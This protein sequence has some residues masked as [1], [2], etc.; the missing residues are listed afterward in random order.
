MFRE[1]LTAQPS[2]GREAGVS[3]LY[4]SLELIN[5][6][7]RD[8]AAQC[9]QDLAP[10]FLPSISLRPTPCYPLCVPPDWAIVTCPH[11]LPPTTVSSFQEAKRYGRRKTM[12]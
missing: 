8:L 12:G 9:S 1:V 10:M 3:S 6:A 5:R 11:N 7:R 4:S 2:R